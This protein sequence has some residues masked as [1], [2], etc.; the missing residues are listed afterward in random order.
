MLRRE[1]HVGLG[2]ILGIALATV[3]SAF[4]LFIFM[5]Q[6][7]KPFTESGISLPA[8]ILAY[9][10]GGVVGGAVFGA[11]LPLTVWRIGATVVGMLAG[12]PVCLGLGSM[13]HGLPWTWDGVA[14]FAWIATAILLGGWGGFSMWEPPAKSD[15]PSP[16]G[17]E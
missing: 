9:L 6:G 2:I 14:W 16:R 5:L 7:S 4:A 1:S 10:A 11:L 17:S 12:I 15:K 3:Y 13:V 8:T